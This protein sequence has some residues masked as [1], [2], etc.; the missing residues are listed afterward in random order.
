V[1]SSET[2]SETLWA[3]KEGLVSLTETVSERIRAH[4]DGLLR[5]SSD[6]V[7]IITET[8]SREQSNAEGRL[9]C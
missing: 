3:H 8:L 1:R 9:T 2:F 4:K 5:S 6:L 7:G